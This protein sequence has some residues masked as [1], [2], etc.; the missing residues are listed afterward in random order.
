MREVCCK[1]L[2]TK[3]TMA[4]AALVLIVPI[5]FLVGLYAAIVGGIQSAN[6][7]AVASGEPSQGRAAEAISLSLVPA[8]VGL[9]LMVPGYVLA[10]LGCLVRS[11]SASSEDLKPGAGK[12][13]VS[14]GKTDRE[15][16]SA[17]GSA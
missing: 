12:H 15:P 2:K 16:T 17:S 5:P 10:A 8:M 4:A 3:P 11:I 14:V 6:L 9:L 7:M 1:A 13:G